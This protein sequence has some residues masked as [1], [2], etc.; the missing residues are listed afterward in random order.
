MVNERILAIGG[1][2][3]FYGGE[4]IDYAEEYDYETDAWNIVGEKLLENMWEPAVAAVPRSYFD[5]ICPGT[6]GPV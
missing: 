1:A 5:D 3:G 4:K 6:G 2:N